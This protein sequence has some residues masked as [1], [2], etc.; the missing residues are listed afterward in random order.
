MLK[1]LCPDCQRVIDAKDRR[2]PQCQER[3]NKA[4]NTDSDR[5]IYRTKQWKKLS[6]LCKQK[7]S[8]LDIYAYFVDGKIVAGKV[9]HHVVPVKDD[10]TRIYDLSNLIYLSSDSH[11]V[12]ESLYR[13]SLQKKRETQKLLWSLIERFES[14]VH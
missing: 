3:Y 10:K 4:H 12:V 1:K 2:C 14:E 8:G 9:S 5:Q 7:F 6:E 11:A 13:E